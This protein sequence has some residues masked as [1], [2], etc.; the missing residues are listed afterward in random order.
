M[1]LNW[2]HVSA[3]KWRPRYAIVERHVREYLAAQRGI[4][5]GTIE[6]AHALLGHDCAHGGRPA[7]GSQE[8]KDASELA[9]MLVK[10]A[11]H[12]GP[13]AT[14]D[15]EKI[16]RYG[17]QWQRWTWR[18]HGSVTAHEGLQTK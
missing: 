16:I 15:G 8:H 4:T 3:L 5:M 9:Q 14:H 18:G 11:P 17:R 1:S 10:M 12:M 6:L 13:L 7:K 2:Q